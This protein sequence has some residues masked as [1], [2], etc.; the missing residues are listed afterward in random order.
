MAFTTNELGRILLELLFPR[1]VTA[2][3]L[4]AA[5]A[6]EISSLALSDLPQD[7]HRAASK[8][9]STGPFRPDSHELLGHI[10]CDVVEL[11]DILDLGVGEKGHRYLRIRKQH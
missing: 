2:G 7:N 4:D 8:S 5:D 3:N 11:V 6:F 10:E 1:S 9:Y